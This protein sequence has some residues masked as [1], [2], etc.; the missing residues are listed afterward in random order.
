M[1]KT[2]TSGA[3]ISI[4]PFLTTLI[5]MYSFLFIIGLYVVTDK[6]KRGKIGFLKFPCFA[7]EK[8]VISKVYYR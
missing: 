4:S 5:E 1:F 3:R 6:E 7:S 8:P 2:K